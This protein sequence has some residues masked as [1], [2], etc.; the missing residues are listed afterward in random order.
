MQN[1]SGMVLIMVGDVKDFAEIKDGKAEFTISGLTADTYN[2]NA[3][4]LGDNKYY[5][6]TETSQVTVS[7]KDTATIEISPEV[8]TEDDKQSIE[9]TLPDDATGNVLVE[10]NGNTFYAEVNGGKVN[11][12]VSG[13]KKQQ[14]K[15]KLQHLKNL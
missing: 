5:N 12:P 8:I 11:V 3:T 7:A 2:I 1:E 4:Y 14:E 6:T 13:L 15:V 9:I 10:V